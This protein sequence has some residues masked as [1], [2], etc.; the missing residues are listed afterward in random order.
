M[1]SSSVNVSLNWIPRAEPAFFGELVNFFLHMR[2]GRP[3]LMLLCD[4]DRSPRSLSG[5]C[6]FCSRISAAEVAIIDD[7]DED[8]ENFGFDSGIYWSLGGPSIIK[9]VLNEISEASALQNE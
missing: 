2:G 9:A 3:S 7:L 4:F 6:S 1:P 5:R 8:R